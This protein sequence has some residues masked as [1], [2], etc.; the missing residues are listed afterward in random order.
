MLPSSMAENTA[1]QE[2]PVAET[3]MAEMMSAAA[4]LPA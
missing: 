2:P 4:T 1:R 3:M